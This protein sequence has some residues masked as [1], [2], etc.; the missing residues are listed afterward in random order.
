[1]L[2]AFV[3]MF[4]T[5]DFKQ[6]Y[7]KLFITA[8]ILLVIGLAIDFACINYASSC[9]KTKLVPMVAS[10]VLGC[11]LVL[12]PIYLI[13]GY[14][15]EMVSNIIDRTDGFSASSVYDGKV[16]RLFQAELPEWNIPKFVWRGFASIVATIILYVPWTILFLLPFIL[17]TGAIMDATNPMELFTGITSIGLPLILLGILS[18][19]IV[20]GLLWNYA[21]QNSVFS[22]LNIFKAI[23]LFGNYTMR[24]FVNGIKFFIFYIADM[25]LS[26][27]L[28]LILGIQSIKTNADFNVLSIT[29]LVIFG[30]IMTLKYLYKIYVYA[31]LLGTLTPSTEG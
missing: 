19:F 29:L 8:V 1:M 18:I 9:D 4:K 30:I 7:L 21:S 2:E 22:M 25:L 10:I 28:V 20:P 26:K 15:W 13:Q 3:W 6:H 16:K 27:C 31:Y 14:F 17:N 11:V 23:Y 5:K 24:Y 12:L